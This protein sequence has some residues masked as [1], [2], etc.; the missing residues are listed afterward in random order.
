MSSRSSLSSSMLENN[1]GKS[2]SKVDCY[3]W[4]LSDFDNKYNIYI[5]LKTS[6]K[7][8]FHRIIINILFFFFNLGYID[9]KKCFQIDDVKHNEHYDN[10]F[11]NFYKTW[12]YK[13]NFLEYTKFSLKYTYT[14]VI[15]HFILFLYKFYFFYFY[16]YFI[17][18]F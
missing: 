12:F 2:N 6:D 7:D 13:I 4:N 10:F 3:Q 16:K 1:C 9:F 14:F 15:Y 11:N 5:I 18:T 8:F 17:Y